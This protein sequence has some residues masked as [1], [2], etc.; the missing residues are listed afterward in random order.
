MRYH[1]SE[2][3]ERV[4]ILLPIR[5]AR[6][7]KHFAVDQGR[8]TS[9]VG[10]QAVVTFLDSIIPAAHPETPTGARGAADL[11]RPLAVDR[12]PTDTDV[13]NGGIL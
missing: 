2:D 10:R 11:H 7:L 5:E 1:R 6:R 13:D 3:F 8:S 9:A 4:T 12:H